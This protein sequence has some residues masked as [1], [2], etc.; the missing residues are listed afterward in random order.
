VA[1]AKNAHKFDPSSEDAAICTICGKTKVKGNH[2]AD[3]KGLLRRVK[4]VLTGAAVIPGVVQAG[5]IAYHVI[6][7]L[8]G[9]L[10]YYSKRRKRP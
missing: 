9:G 10:F 4:G 7:R 8:Y 5:E 3:R 2:I 1:A 6:E